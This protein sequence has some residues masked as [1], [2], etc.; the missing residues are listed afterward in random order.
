MSFIAA[1]VPAPHPSGERPEI[2]HGQFDDRL[3]GAHLTSTRPLRTVV[4]AARFGSAAR[5]PSTFPGRFARLV[6]EWFL[7]LLVLV[8]P[9]DVLAQTAG[10][11]DEDRDWGVEPVAEVRPKAYHAPTPITIPGA[12]V[13]TT[14][15]LRQMLDQGPRP[16]LVDVLSGQAHR[17]L[18][19]SVWLNN[20][21]L[22]DFDAEEEKRFL[23]AIAKF[24]GS[25][26]AKPIAFF[27]SGVECWLSYNA[28]LRTA[29]A[30]YTNV[31]WYRGGIDSWRAAGHPV[32]T[33]DPFPW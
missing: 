14:Q 27:C 23:V 17:T 32:V 31:L 18:P 28:A 19:G 16:F 11:G 15:A 5:M 7:V 4:R 26:K 24:V 3:T 2:M 21:G 6:R 29:K 10:P 1:A 33:A 8:V 12:R 9:A 30:G 13:V 25:D 20:G 22:G